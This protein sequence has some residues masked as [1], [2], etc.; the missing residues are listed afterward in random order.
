MLHERQK[1]I[2]TA[3]FTATLEIRILRGAL[4]QIFRS[5][6]TRYV[7]SFARL[8]SAN[9]NG[10]S[11][12][13]Q[14]DSLVAVSADSFLVAQDNPEEVGNAAIFDLYASASVFF[15]FVQDT[16]SASGLAFR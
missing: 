8:A 13:G 4:R 2:K 14:D 5:W 11:F 9:E 3:L 15:T 16:A 1:P 10:G 12:S 6:D 7:R